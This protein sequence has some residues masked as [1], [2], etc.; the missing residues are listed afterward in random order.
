VGETAHTRWIS[1]AARPDFARRLFFHPRIALAAKCCSR[2]PLQLAELIGF[3]FKVEL[4][5]KWFDA[6]WANRQQLR[7]C[8]L[9]DRSGS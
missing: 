9:G 8:Y 4:S 5:K 6:Y 2:Q 7:S 3:F 1:A